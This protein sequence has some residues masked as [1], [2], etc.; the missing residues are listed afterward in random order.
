MKGKFYTLL[1]KYCGI[2]FLIISNYIHFFIIVQNIRTRFYSKYIRSITITSQNPNFIRKN[3]HDTLFMLLFLNQN[4]T[5][6]FYI[7]KI[8]YC[9]ISK[10]TICFDGSI[11][12]PCSLSLLCIH[13]K[14]EAMI[15]IKK[16]PLW[17]KL[18]ITYLIQFQLQCSQSL[19]VQY[20]HRF[21]KRAKYVT[22]NINEEYNFAFYKEKQEKNV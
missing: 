9:K 12:N 10:R 8:M 13:A 16:N 3:K 18:G 5:M 6:K 21:I 22:Y 20:M 1:I 4:S 19:F 7:Q 2:D 15:E 11:V 14:F 17:S